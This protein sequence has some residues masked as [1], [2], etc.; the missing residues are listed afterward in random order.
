MILTG[1][2]GAEE[3]RRAIEWRVVFLIA[4]T[5]PLGLALEET[6]VA[7][8]VAQA[9]LGATAPL[10]P[11]ATIAGLFLIASAISVTSSNSAAAVILAPIAAEVATHG[12]LELE[13]ALLAVAY[14]CAC[15]FILPLAQTNLIVMGPGGY[16]ARDYLRFGGG[17][18]V[19]MAA[20]KILLLA[21]L[22]R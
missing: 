11:S 3:A 7:A 18:S 12:T 21:V 10:G 5:L 9:I 15:A 8:A 6:G 13:V 19:V 17:L 20:T 4:G 22:P 2:V 16:R 14:G 1:C